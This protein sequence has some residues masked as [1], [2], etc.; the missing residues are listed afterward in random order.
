MEWPVSKFLS[1]DAAVDRVATIGNR[2]VG[3]KIFDILAA[4]RLAD[5]E[6]AVFQLLR[7][8]RLRVVGDV[9]ELDGSSVED[10]VP[11]AIWLHATSFL[12]PRSQGSKTPSHMHG[13]PIY[14][15]GDNAIESDVVSLDR[16]GTAVV[17]VDERSDAHLLIDGED[18]TVRA[19][20]APRDLTPTTRRWINLRVDA[21]AF[22]EAAKPLIDA[23]WERWQLWLRRL[24]SAEPMLSG[25]PVR[26]K[27]YICGR[28]VRALAPGE[29]AAWQPDDYSLEADANPSALAWIE[30]VLSGD[31]ALCMLE[32][33]AEFNAYL[34]LVRALRR[35][36]GDKPMPV[37]ETFRK[38]MKEQFPELGERAFKRVWAAAVQDA[39]GTWSK[40]GRHPGSRPGAAD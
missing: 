28:L 38:Q 18:G 3:R 35:S 5:S 9:A 33:D 6:R 17:V 12:E 21:T 24:V 16:G 39:G 8:H 27:S 31:A 13:R 34:W 23:E 2:L 7:D 22:A 15:P 26:V 32:K 19:L 4:E 37:K 30:H 10:E 20:A 1:L 25:V 14:F 40:A 11:R 36:E 29:K